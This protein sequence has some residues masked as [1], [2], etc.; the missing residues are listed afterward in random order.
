MPKNGYGSDQRPVVI[1]WDGNEPLTAAETIMKDELA[2]LYGHR[3]L[4]HCLD[5]E[6]AN[7]LLTRRKNL[8]NLRPAIVVIYD[9]AKESDIASFF[10]DFNLESDKKLLVVVCESCKLPSR[11][12]MG[13]DE[14]I[15]LTKEIT[16][17]TLRTV[18]ENFI[19]TAVEDH[20]A[21]ED[22]MAKHASGH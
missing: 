5:P 14:M 3:N 2:D 18:L 13:N 10:H 11:D 19:G 16:Q 21:V 22:L 15:T 8:R 7:D 9:P 1:V 12:D 17:G 4:H 20:Q 6:E